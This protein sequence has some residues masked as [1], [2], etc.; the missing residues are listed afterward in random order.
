MKLTAKEATDA[1]TSA[2]STSPRTE[3]NGRRPEPGFGPK[4]GKWSSNFILLARTILGALWEWLLGDV[5]KAVFEESRSGSR[6]LQACRCLSCSGF[7]LLRV[8]PCAQ[9]RFRSWDC[10]IQAGPCAAHGLALLVFS[11]LLP[12]R[13]LPPLTYG[14]PFH[15][16]WSSGCGCDS[17]YKFYSN[18]H[19]DM[20]IQDLCVSSE[21]HEDV[22]ST[23]FIVRCLCHPVQAL[24]P[25]APF[26]NQSRSI[27]WASYGC[28]GAREAC[29]QQV[30]KWTASKPSF[31]ITTK[32]SSGMYVWHYHLTFLL[33]DDYRIPN[34][35]SWLPRLESLNS[36]T[37]QRR[38]QQ[39][40]RLP[41]RKTQRKLW[42]N[43]NLDPY[44]R[45]LVGDTH[46]EL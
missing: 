46:V 20:C 19:Q 45:D 40:Q 6:R 29:H 4:S 16:R 43:R 34:L 37:P 10:L 11:M 23:C 38:R 30:I 41:Q 24:I 9:V 36:I 17:L 13:G 33:V 31:S 27:I 44:H 15:F 21:I 14:K 5:V 2:N 28:Y 35:S 7:A 1:N 26:T 12:L 3:S 8:F 32:V 42:Y 25:S 39:K 18:C 22:A